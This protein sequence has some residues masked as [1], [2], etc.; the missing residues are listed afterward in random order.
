MN[1]DTN[2]DYEL[3]Q[4]SANNLNSTNVTSSSEVEACS[5]MIEKLQSCSLKHGKFLSSID[6]E[7]VSNSL[8]AANNSYIKL[9][10]QAAGV[11]VTF[12][13]ADN[14]DANNTSA[15]NSSGGASTS[16][17][18]GG[19]GGG[20][21]A[22]GAAVIN[23]I[24]GVDNN[25]N[26]KKKKKKK[27]NKDSKDKDKDK[28][29][30]SKDKNNKKKKKKNKNKGK[31]KNGIA[32]ISTGVA[33]SSI[34]DNEAKILREKLI[35][36]QY[37]KEKEELQKAQEQE[38]L[39]KRQEEEQYEQEQIRIEEEQRAQQ[40]E[41]Y[42]QQQE[43]KKVAEEQRQKELEQQ[44]KEAE[45][46]AQQQKQQQ[47]MQKEQEQLQQQKQ[48]LEKQR[49]QQMLEEAKVSG[50]N[51]STTNQATTS[52]LASTASNSASSIASGLVDNIERL[53][54]DV[55]NALGDA[56]ASSGVVADG[57]LSST[58]NTLFAGNTVDSSLP[59]V[60]LSKTKTLKGGLSVG[61]G[62][63]AA[64][65]A[66]VT[67]KKVL[68]SKD[69]N[70]MELEDNLSLNGNLSIEDDQKQEEFLDD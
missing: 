65:A 4:I 7:L 20:G 3:I 34:A 12:G 68:D 44:Q 21:A 39:K 16:G 18:S 62:L 27:K 42:K 58:G 70:S 46:Q 50:N 14:L 54:T 63:L 2:A 43:Q 66:G 37:R 5:K 19:G 10:D 67:T 61:L 13:G 57:F 55:N 69:K 31:V 23:S 48:E 28:T 33:T 11:S 53:G 22:G 15:Q 64:T 56:T 59:E 60:D 25:S 40:E 49:Q 38:E 41:L 32:V 47:Q 26:K 24:T 8:V 17:S 35:E 45:L 51:A 52:S 1:G 29:K 30:D 36:E 6:F 9:Q